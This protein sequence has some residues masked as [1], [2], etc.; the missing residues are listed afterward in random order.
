M[1]SSPVDGGV[2]LLASAGLTSAGPPRRA[3]PTAGGTGFPSPER[4]PGETAA[5]RSTPA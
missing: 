1:E 2:V 5:C 3:C 4:E